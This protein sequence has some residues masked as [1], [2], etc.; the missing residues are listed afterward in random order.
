GRGRGGHRPRVLRLRRG[1]APGADRPVGRRPRRAGAAAPPHPV[2]LAAPP[3]QTAI[4]VIAI[5]ASPKAVCCSP[6]TLAGLGWPRTMARFVAATT[7]IAASAAVGT[8]PS[9]Q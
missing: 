2:P 1:G 4:A 8:A 5:T 6:I 9:H 7:A 3:A